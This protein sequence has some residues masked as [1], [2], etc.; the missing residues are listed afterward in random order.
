MK[1]NLPQRKN[2]RLKYYKYSVDGYYFITIC[3]KE[4]LELLGK[5]GVG[6]ALLGD[7]KTSNIMTLSKEGE[8]VKKHIENCNKRIENVSIDEYMKNFNEDE[9]KENEIN[10]LF[11]EDDIFPNIPI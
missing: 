5:I 4:R 11:N 3:V 1:D 9:F 6:V 10:S 2:I 7:P 8:I